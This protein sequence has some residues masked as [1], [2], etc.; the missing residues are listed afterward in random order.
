V[1]Q[2]TFRM[3]TLT[4]K[5]TS[6]KK[7]NLIEELAK[8]LG[9]LVEKSVEV[10]KTKTPNSTTLKAIKEAKAEKMNIIEFRKLLYS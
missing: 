4:L 5:T 7:L 8:E 9:I 10:R 3:T 1:L 6:K 2:Y